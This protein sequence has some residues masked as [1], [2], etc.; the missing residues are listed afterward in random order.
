V[1]MTQDLKNSGKGLSLAHFLL[2]S[3]CCLSAAVTYR[4]DRF[5]W[6]FS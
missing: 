5:S 6:Y 1:K 3:F 4:F 2:H